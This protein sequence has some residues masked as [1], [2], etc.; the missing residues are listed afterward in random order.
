MA[1]IAA[2][3][4]S[5]LRGWEPANE[6]GRTHQKEGERGDWRIY[7][8]ADPFGDATRHHPVGSR[9]STPDREDEGRA[10][11]IACLGVPNRR[12]SAS[13]RSPP[14]N[15]RVAQPPGIASQ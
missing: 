7:T 12:K 9:P 10:S 8:V 15:L 14:S 13:L 6:E 3:A 2:L 11:L 1:K 4:A 5:L